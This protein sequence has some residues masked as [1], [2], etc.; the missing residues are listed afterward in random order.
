M[1][2]S[3]LPSTISVLGWKPVLKNGADEYSVD[4]IRLTVGGH[5]ITNIMDWA[6]VPPVV[7]RKSALQMLFDATYDEEGNQISWWNWI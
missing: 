2:I 4:H 1:A 6:V 3:D 5:M 7:R